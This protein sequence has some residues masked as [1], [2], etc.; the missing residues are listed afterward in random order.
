MLPAPVAPY[1][2][3]RSRPDGPSASALRELEF[4]HLLA[5]APYDQ[6]DDLED[7]QAAQPVAA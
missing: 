1:L 6:G 4:L 2:D 7:P 3:E 5:V